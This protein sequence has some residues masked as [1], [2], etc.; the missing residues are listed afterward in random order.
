MPP[1]TGKD[2]SAQR[3][4]WSSVSVTLS[5]TLDRAVREGELLKNSTQRP[6]LRSV[7]TAVPRFNQ[8]PVST[9]SSGT[10]ELVIWLRAGERYLC[11]LLDGLPLRQV[12][13]EKGGRLW[14]FARL[15][16]GT[17]HVRMTIGEAEMPRGSTSA[18]ARIRRRQEWRV[19]CELTTSQE[20]VKTALLVH[21]TQFFAAVI[22]PADDFIL[23]SIPGSCDSAPGPSER[24]HL[25]HERR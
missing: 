15:E 14:R 6:P 20:R 10:R 13:V 16:L 3:A 21:K 18:R 8:R 1:G 24:R 7:R 4:N 25:P 11:I 17:W 19:S 12:G 22:V 9:A 2:S 5:S 23:E